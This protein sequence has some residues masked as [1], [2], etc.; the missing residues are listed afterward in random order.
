MSQTISKMDPD[1]KK[2]KIDWFN[3]KKNR[4]WH[5]PRRSVLIYF[6]SSLITSLILDCYSV[7]L[8]IS[9]FPSS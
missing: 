6:F 7:F 1:D 3:L 4:P 8:L 2:I 5:N 9:R